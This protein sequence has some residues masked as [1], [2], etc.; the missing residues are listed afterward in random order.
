[1]ENRANIS[2][3]LSDMQESTALQS[4]QIKT[5]QDSTIVRML[6]LDR[7]NAKAPEAS[8]DNVDI[9]AKVHSKL[10]KNVPPKHLTSKWN[11]DIDTRQTLTEQETNSF[12][13]ILQAQS[14]GNNVKAKHSRK[15]SKLIK[16]MFA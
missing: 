1:M 2:V 14:N 16:N 7:V 11:K 6:P 3:S 13:G 15:C 12:P 4:V 9:N 5:E 8:F 10:N